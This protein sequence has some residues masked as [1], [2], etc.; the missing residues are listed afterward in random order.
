MDIS[1]ARVLDHDIYTLECTARHQSSI[2]V[3]ASS[4]SDPPNRHRIRRLQTQIPLQMII[5]IP[6]GT[7][8]QIRYPRI[9]HL[10]NVPPIRRQRVAKLVPAHRV[11]SSA[12]IAAHRGQVKMAQGKGKREPPTCR[13]ST[14]T[15]GPRPHCSPRDPCAHTSAAPC[16]AR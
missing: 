16:P 14:Y 15:R 11:V 9:S 3:R 10:Y 1:I 7:L 8:H 6:L 13:T 12:S 4:L 5:Q 2:T